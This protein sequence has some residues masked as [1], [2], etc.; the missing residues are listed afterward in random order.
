GPRWA[1]SSKRSPAARE[2]AES[3]TAAHDPTMKRNAPGNDGREVGHALK[4]RARSALGQWLD[5]PLGLPVAA[6]KQPASSTSLEASMVSRS[7]LS[8]GHRLGGPVPLPPARS[9]SSAN[10]LKGP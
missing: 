9:P 4:W 1:E 5:A 8:S 6:A 3:K 10:T 7:Q 2:A